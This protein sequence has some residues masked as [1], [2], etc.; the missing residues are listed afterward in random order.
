MRTELSLKSLKMCV[1][2]SSEVFGP[3]KNLR[4][5]IFMPTALAPV[6]I[7]SNHVPAKHRWF[8]EVTGVTHV[9]RELPLKRRW[10]TEEIR[11][12]H[13]KFVNEDIL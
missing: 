4:N 9:A 8:T 5:F 2:T 11:V 13:I 12:R 1:C 6:R 7:P 3:V 10:F